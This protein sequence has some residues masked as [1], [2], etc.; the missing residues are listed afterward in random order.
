LTTAKQADGKV[1]EA[2]APAPGRELLKGGAQ[3]TEF[4]L[5]RKAER[6]D[7]RWL[8]GQL[9]TFAGVIWRLKEDGELLSWTDE[10]TGLLETKAAEAKAA[11]VA[12]VAAKAA[13]KEAL[14]K[15]AAAAASRPA[16]RKPAPKAAAARRPPAR[17]ASTQRRGRVPET[18]A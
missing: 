7:V 16:T 18:V 8:Y 15:D 11:A 17:E 10:L 14:L 1:M 9:P 2:L 5:K 4:I 6:E 12:A 3:I 13:E